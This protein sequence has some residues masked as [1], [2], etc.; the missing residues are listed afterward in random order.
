MSEFKSWLKN[1]GFFGDTFKSAKDAFFNLP[2]KSTTTQTILNHPKVRSHIDNLSNKLGMGGVD[3]DKT[4]KPV[5]AELVPTTPQQEYE[6]IKKNIE[7]L[8]HIRFD[9]M[10]KNEPTLL[11]KINDSISVIAKQVIFKKMKPEYNGE[12]GRLIGFNTFN[13]L[14]NIHRSRM[15]KDIWKE[16]F[17]RGL[18]TFIK[19]GILLSEDLHL[20]KSDSDQLEIFNNKWIE[21]LKT[22]SN[23][24]Q[25]NPYGP[26][27]NT[28]VRFNVAQEAEKAIKDHID[29]MKS[30]GR[31]PDLVGTDVYTYFN[32]VRKD[33]L[34]QGY[35][36]MNDDHDAAEDLIQRLVQAKLVGY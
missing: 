15:I 33:A 20:S 36:L 34:A 2:H 29:R 10:A 12:F 35:L 31:K 30:W 22:I 7:D 24:S 14:E 28:N 16:R 8:V 19:T 13:I 9:S 23:Q 25:Q 26:G 32:K 6:R 21:H 11:K 1:E 5:N 18:I 17:C 3:W 4:I 27:P